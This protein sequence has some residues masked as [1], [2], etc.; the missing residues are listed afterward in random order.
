[1]TIH[2]RCENNLLH[3]R[4]EGEL[5]EHNASTARRQADALIDTHAS[6]TRAVF[7]LASVSFMDSTGIG[8]LIGRYKRFHKRGVPMYL[9]NASKAT[10]K[11][12]EISGIYTLIPKL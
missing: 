11:I 5:D 3:I 6:C 2:A 4:L 1:M 12:L 7:D 8:F 9:T 10:D